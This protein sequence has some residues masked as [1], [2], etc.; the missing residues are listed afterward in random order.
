M[1]SL[2]RPDRQAISERHLTSRQFNE[3]ASLVANITE[4]DVLTDRI[5]RFVRQ[6]LAT[7]RVALFL[8]TE[9]GEPE[10]AGALGADGE[11]IE[12]IAA[13]SRGIM[14]EAVE[15][16]GY[17]HIADALTHSE[18][19]RRESV[20]QLNVR[21][22]LATPLLRQGRVVGILYADTLDV[23]GAFVE[24]DRDFVEG[25]AH[26]L[27]SAL[28]QSRRLQKII[29][30]AASPRKP[31]RGRLTFPGVVADSRRMQKTLRLAM[32]VAP[33]E[34]TVILMGEPGTGKEVLADLI[35]QY[36]RRSR[37]PYL[38]INCAA[39]PEANLESELFG[40]AAGAFTG[41][42]AREG[43]F[44][45]ANGGTLFLDE[46]GEMRPASQAALLRVLEE[47]YI[48][49]VGGRRLIS[50]DVRILAAT[51]CDLEQ[52]VKDGRFRQDL[53]DRLNQFAV[54]L[55]PLREH[56]EDIPGMV[57][58]FLDREKQREKIEREITIEPPIMDW[59]ADA[60]LPGNARELANIVGKMLALDTDGMLGWDDI[61]PD[62]KAVRQL[63]SPKFDEDSSFDN[64][65]AMAEAT[66]LRRAIDNADGRIRKAARSLEMPEATL[67]R[68]LKMLDLHHPTM[69]QMVRSRRGRR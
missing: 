14:A 10:L 17:L 51:N 15:K 56:R 7:D 3:I 25:L 46:I 27:A 1:A 2:K 33:T 60:P 38:K 50:V 45:L 18:L 40:V 58:M 13:F 49:R 30:T 26:L 43:M 23:P 22:V 57:Q 35:Q 64:M 39:V 21:S 11:Q 9:D 48:R 16:G 4:P 12:E 19:G 61:P 44:E 59:L 37:L 31:G 8:V 54:H 36:S 69:V 6:E 32:R 47:R 55:A 67:R 62:M 53:Y 52:A 24:S 34:K 65:M 66:I 41:V 28:E 63:Q 42:T 68:R 20:R 29:H 5:L